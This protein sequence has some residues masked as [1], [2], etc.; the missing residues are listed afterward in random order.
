MSTRLLRIGLTGIILAAAAMI[1]STITHAADPGKNQGPEQERQKRPAK[2]GEPA[3]DFSLKDQDGKSVRLST[4]KGKIVVLH[5]FNLRCP[6]FE[7]HCKAGTF[8]SI[9]D[10]YKGKGVVQIAIDSTGETAE[11][12]KKAAEL[13]RVTYPILR[14]DGGKVA[15]AYRARTTPHV[16]IIAADGKLAYSGAVDSDPDGKDPKRIDYVRQALE[17][18]LTGREV[19]VAETRPYGCEV[20]YQD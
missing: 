5:W 17:E 10:Q 18:L 15:R 6:I 1:C 4:Y 13:F 19:S 3:P 2:V 8:A 9:E 11:E 14:D 20:R 12:H 16:F 7:R